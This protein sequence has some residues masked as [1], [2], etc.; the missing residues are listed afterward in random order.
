V[1]FSKKIAAVSIVAASAL[2]AGGA[3]A[4]WTTN[5]DGDGSANAAGSNGDVVL[6]A[7]FDAGITPGGSED[8]TF[9]ADNL[10]TT[11]LWVETLSIDSITVDNAYDADSNPTGCDAADFTVDEDTF[12]EQT[13]IP[14]G[15][16]GV[17]LDSETVLN[18]ANTAVNQDGCKGVTVTLTLSSV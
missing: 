13:M 14:A 7:S 2:V 1:R 12:T 8:V 16:S 15:D 17:L 10:G 11:N 18:F 6:H 4:Y 3:F 9:S 5:G